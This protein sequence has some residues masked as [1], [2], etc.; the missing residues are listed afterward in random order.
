MVGFA[1]A[2]VTMD[3]HVDGLQ[4][5]SDVPPIVRNR[6]YAWAAS[7]LAIT[8]AALFLQ[9]Q[10]IDNAPPEWDEAMFLLDGLDEFQASKIGGLGGFYKT[11]LTTNP[12]RLGLLPLIAQPGFWIFGPSPD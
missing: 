3:E 11:F 7:L 5:H 1:A 12:G 4:H 8:F 2:R 10:I 6:H 9:W